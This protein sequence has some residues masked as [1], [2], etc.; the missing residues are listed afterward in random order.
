MQLQDYERDHLAMLRPC[1]SECAVLLKKNGAFPLD[2]PCDLALY[3]SGA[4]RTVFGGTG[5]GEVNARHFVSVEEGLEQAGFR[6][7]TKNW[8][9]QYDA[10]EAEAKA[11]FL[12]QIK[13]D[14]RRHRRLAVLEGM[15]AV[16]PKPEYDLP[17]TAHGDAAVYVLSRISG[18]GSDRTVEGDVLLTKSEIRDILALDRQFDRFLLVLNVGGPVDLSPVQSVGNILLLSQLGTETGPALADMLLGRRSPSGKLSTTWAAWEDYP[19]LGDFGER[20]DSRYREGVYVGYR[21]FDSVGKRALYPFGYGLSYADFELHNA[22]ASLE[23]ERVTVTAAVENIGEH[24]GKET[25]QLYVSVPWGR[26]DQP[27]QT[28]AAFQK[29]RTL[30]PGEKETLTMS[31]DLHELASCDTA[32]S[33]FLLE[34]GDYVLRLGQNSADSEPFAILRLDRE[35]I[36]AK[37]RAL[38]GPDYEDWKPEKPAVQPLSKLPVLTVDPD[39]IP[40]LVPKYDVPAPI[41]PLAASLPDETLAMMSVGAFDPKG[42]MLSVIGNASTAVP[43]AAGESSHALEDSGVPFLVMADGPAGLRLTRTFARDRKG[44]VPLESTMPATI[45]DLLPGVV[46]K[47]LSL[48]QRKP[49]PDAEIVTQ[50]CTAI[51]IGT[52][53]AQSWNPAFA[54]LCG[55]LVGAEMERF[56][57][58]LWL[59]PALN[60]H[61]DIRCGRNFEYYSEDPFL[62]GRMAAAVTRGV[63]AHPGRA[64]TIK[65]YC[66][67]NQETNRFQSNS[68]VSHRA[69]RELYLRGFGI[70][71]REGNPRAVMTSYNLLNGVHTSER[72][73]LIEDILRA[74]FGFDG[75]VMTDWLIAQMKDKRARHPIAHPERIPASGND[76]LMPGTK[77]DCKS[78]LNALRSGA[79]DR[80]Q[81]RRNVSRLIRLAR[82]L[83]A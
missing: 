51:P 69:L 6:L 54:K 23:G 11:A 66:A 46:T 28:L 8:L 45:A 42:G 76:V 49:L 43:G 15:G 7:T 81:V 57:V 74:E 75:L 32:R 77:G 83:N 36:T 3:G 60:L 30:Y 4:R 40:C 47:A 10:V 68:Q 48:T 14:A 35:V 21:Y 33:A 17:L 52:A 29:S 5:S 78:I 26:L 72:R 62:S 56:G 82:E 31:F 79:L 22:K 73:D 39:Q 16:M 2:W 44:I 19:H 12:R 9:D 67:N 55:D 1:L 27:F 50:Y 20:D 61:R 59:A 71:V 37:L 25:A 24:T 80:D 58:Q 65:H 70:A 53:L 13:A 34:P 41:D 18:E 63:Q 64:V 38:D